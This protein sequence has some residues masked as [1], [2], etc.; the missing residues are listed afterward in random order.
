MR[1]KHATCNLFGTNL[2][3]QQCNFTCYSAV[4]RIFLCFSAQFFLVVLGCFS[5]SGLKL[6]AGC[7]QKCIKMY[8]NVSKSTKT[9]QNVFL[10]PLKASAM[11]STSVVSAL[12]VLVVLGCFFQFRAQFVCRLWAF[13]SF[14]VLNCADLCGIVPDY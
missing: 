10:C 1:I 13:L 8:Q 12:F 14:F 9:Y 6:F 3:T 2:P 11:F 4:G 7:V 5:F